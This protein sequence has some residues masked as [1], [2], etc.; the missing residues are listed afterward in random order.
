MSRIRLPSAVKSLSARLL[1]LTIFFVMLA[2]VLTYVPSIARFRMTE[3][4]DR[5]QAAHLAVM[6]AQDSERLSPKAEAGMLR[7]A[8]VYAVE[9][10][11]PDGTVRSLGTSAH[12]TPAQ[13]YDLR[14]AGLVDMVGNAFD[15]LF[16]GGDRRLRVIGPVPGRDDAVLTVDLDEGPLRAAMIDYSERILA[17][18]LVISIFTATLVYIALTL[19]MVRPMRRLT[20]SM[21]R[22]REDPENP[23]SVITASGRDD[24]IGTA[25]AEL[26]SMQERLTN[27]L[28]QKERMAALG[29]AVTKI[30]H[31]LKNILATARLVSD[32]M[33]ES[34]DPEV[35]RMAP[36]LVKTIDRAVN[37][38]VQTLTYAREGPV[39]LDLDTVDLNALVS[40]VAAGLPVA[41]PDQVRV[42][43]ELPEGFT[44]TADREQ[45]YRVFAN[46]AQNAVEAGATHLRVHGGRKARRT[47]VCISDN[48]PGLP[49]TIQDTVFQPFQTA[50]KTGSSG[51]GLAIARDLVRAHGGEITVV[52]TSGEGTEFRIDLP[53]RAA[54]AQAV[55][56]AA[57]G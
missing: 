34:E 56:R 9:L 53:D 18:S 1:V 15:T 19:L 13:T 24:E 45:L 12:V 16:T 36:R 20:D 35:A 44:A 6:A 5:L 51:L 54:A 42:D 40:E 43:N 33:G 25:E 8:Q 55:P 22:F 37:L 11:R 7:E 49:P 10:H 57:A 17:L 30:N 41:A 23:D 39:Q 50:G 32:R 4:Q 26:A 38:C 29:V 48:G 47:L 3:L 14:R 46:I 27:A 31:D 28:R 21:M 52:S 2:E